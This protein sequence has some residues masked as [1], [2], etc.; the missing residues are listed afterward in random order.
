MP[1]D[2]TTSASGSSESD[3]WLLLLLS[4]FL[5][6]T[7]AAGTLFTRLGLAPLAGELIVGALLGPQLLGAV[8]RGS[9]AALSTIGQLG[10]YSLVLES[11]VDIE[12]SAL[13]GVGWRALGASLTGVLLGAGPLAFG[14]AKSLGYSTKT[15][16]AIAASLTP[17]STGIAVTSLK[18]FRASNTPTGLLIVATAVVEDTLT[19]TLLSG[20][21]CC[22]DAAVLL[23]HLLLAELRVLH[24]ATHPWAFVKPVLAALGTHPPPRSSPRW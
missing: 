18:R 8:P 3:V 21:P 20:A 19:L 17:A 1:R 4:A 23:A 14:I 9:A 22:L 24:T 13:R 10:L 11:G 15:A 16:L 6:A 2:G 12:L 5:A 7:W